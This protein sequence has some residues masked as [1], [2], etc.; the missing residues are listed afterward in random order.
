MVNSIFQSRRFIVASFFFSIVQL[1]FLVLL[2]KDMIKPGTL[3]FE[4][5]VYLSLGILFAYFVPNVKLRKALF[6][7]LLFEFLLTFVSII[8]NANVPE[9][10]KL[11]IN[12]PYR[13]IQQQDYFDRH[14][15]LQVVPRK[16]VEFIDDAG[17]KV[18]H[19][20]LG[21]R[22]FDIFAD[23]KYP[24]INFYGGSTTYNGGINQGS[25]WI[26]KLYENYTE[27]PNNQEILFLNR[28]MLGYSS[29][30]A[31]LQTTFYN[32]LTT[33]QNLCNVYYMGWNDLRN[34]DRPTQDR[35]YADYWLTI[36]YSARF[37]RAHLIE[38]SPTLKSIYSLSQ[39]ILLKDFPR[40]N[41]ELSLANPNTI[42]SSYAENLS[43]IAAINQRRGIQTVFI[44][45]ILNLDTISSRERELL[46]LFNSKMEQVARRNSVGFV[47]INSKK[48]DLNDFFDGGHF[49]YSGT[50]KFSRMI[51]KQV[52]SLC[53][54]E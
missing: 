47:N 6:L 49:N 41:E 45:Q 23:S 43:T 3:R 19:N 46:D 25:T 30:E 7:W 39:A 11:P 40:P 21:I 28:G 13:E 26:E 38:I 14:Q 31:L 29:V 17:G 37:P 12:W 10:W 50:V 22:G 8:S 54:L 1:F 51:A 42:A 44:P 52:F 34:V 4:F 53:G 20:N 27:I 24:F 5:Y 36:Q 35:A 33:G 2:L 32:S 48:F 16:D 9:K 15:L 18:I